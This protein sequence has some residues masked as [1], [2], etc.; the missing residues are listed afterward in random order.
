MVWRFIKNLIF[1][2]SLVVIV[3]VALYYLWAPRYYFPQTEVF[4]GNKIYNPY[5]NT[6]SK[7]WERVGLYT[8]PLWY[9]DIMD[10][11]TGNDQHIEPNP[12]YYDTII[13][14]SNQK[15]SDHGNVYMQGLVHDDHL[16][17]GCD[18]IEWRDY[19]FIRDIHNKQH[20]INLIKHHGC[21]VY[22][23]PSVFLEDFRQDHPV[24]LRNYDGLLMD[25]SVVQAL[26]F[27]DQT[28]SSGHYTTILAKTLPESSR[29]MP[30]KYHRIL[31]VNR[32]A[33][34]LNEAFASGN[35]FLALQYEYDGNEA[36]PSMKSKL[37]GVKVERDSVWVNTSTKAFAI[38]FFGQNGN[39][40]KVARDTKT[41]FYALQRSDTYIRIEIIFEDGARYYLNP[42]S[43]YSGKDPKAVIGVEVNYLKTWLL[44]GAG[45]LALLFV[46]WI[47]FYIKR[48]FKIEFVE[49]KE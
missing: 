40:L 48:R 29:L 42:V 13:N 12:Y 32:N 43:R 36:K 39:V 3:V 33:G 18:D 45:I 35:Y 22:L 16:V 34:T 44:R 21:L 41:A 14:I 4:Y 7:S 1:Y 37:S 19:P 27:W 8:H 11:V 31:Y 9:Q 23:E 26:H 6:D 47:L 10:R 38:N 2:I 30:E 46:I 49:V 17:M 25:E 28:L 20:R 5:K 15:F 24:L